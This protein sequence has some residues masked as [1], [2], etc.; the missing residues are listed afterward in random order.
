M[1][2]LSPT[3]DPPLEF[4]ARGMA[5]SSKANEFGDVAFLIGVWERGKK[6]DPGL[7]VDDT[8]WGINTYLFCGVVV[9]EKSKKAEV[10]CETL[11]KP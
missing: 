1:W 10:L 6:A 3:G 4:H 7:S 11:K 2:L 9:Y 8:S 5:P